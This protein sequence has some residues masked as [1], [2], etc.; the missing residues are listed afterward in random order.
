MHMSSLKDELGVWTDVDRAGFSLARCLG[1]M[2]PGSRFEREAKYVFWS[3]NPV[4]N[5]LYEMLESL[6]EAG[7]LKR[8]NEPDL[9]YRWNAAFQGNWQ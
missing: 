5:L 2:G 6:V 4:G 3:D 9:Q 7:V 1:L 8:R